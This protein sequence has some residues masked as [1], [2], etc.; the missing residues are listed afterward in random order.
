[1]GKG[2]G[3]EVVEVDR[4]GLNPQPLSTSVERGSGLIFINNTFTSN[5]VMNIFKQKFP[6]D[7]SLQSHLKR[8]LI[9][10]I[11][12]AVFLLV[13]KPFDLDT[14]PDARLV[15]VCGIYGLTTFTCILCAGLIL[16]ALFPSFFNEETWTTGKQIILVAGI[17]VLI[18]LANFSISPF[19]VESSL[20]LRSLLWFQGITVLVSLLPITMYTLYRQN[21]LLKKFELQASVLEKKLQ[22]KLDPVKKEEPL[23]PFPEKKN[24]FPTIELTGDYQGEKLVLPPGD[25]YY[26]AAANNY[27]KVYFIKKGTVTYSIIRM[28]MK[29]AEEALMPWPDFYRCHRAYI[30]NL[31]KVKHVEGNAQGYKLRLAD[32]EEAI[33]VSRNLNSEFADKLLALRNMTD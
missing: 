17:V 28:T 10:G 9:F 32:V 11:F 23:P 14:L 2:T 19:I 13:F 18:G 5:Y 8:A 15:F 29:K 26:I 1:L 24:E 31:D 7:F 21:R 33:P 25:L 20:T 6:C 30:V 12:V 16:P 4:V 22:E 27:I 3:G